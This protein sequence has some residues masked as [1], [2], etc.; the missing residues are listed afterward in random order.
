MHDFDSSK[1][2]KISFNSTGSIILW[3]NGFN[4]RVLYPQ[5]FSQAIEQP[6]IYRNPTTLFCNILKIR[7]FN[8]CI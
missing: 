6:Y 5:T 4:G 1:M 2:Q 7:S 8:I 3:F